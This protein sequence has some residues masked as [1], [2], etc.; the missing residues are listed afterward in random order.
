MTDERSIKLAAFVVQALDLEDDPAALAGE[1]VALKRDANAGISSIELDSS[2]G[3]AAFLVYH[4]LLDVS[5]EK[6]RLGRALFDA[7]LATLQRTAARETP[8][9]RI[10]A[11]ATTGDEAY[12]LATT[13]A[14]YRALTGMPALDDLRATGTDLSPGADTADLRRTTAG[15]L[16][17]LLR[18]SDTQAADWLRAVRTEGRSASEAEELPLVFNEEETALA[19]FL[20]DERSIGNLLQVLNVVLTS[21]R[22]QTA[23]A[24]GDGPAGR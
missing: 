10:L 14:S 15:E 13:P 18:E 11:H 20:L 21:A 3:P 1:F 4:Y 19:L 12:V 7:D 17:R 9:P 6:G 22:R 5:D 2:I 16:L 23:E 24:L 8:G